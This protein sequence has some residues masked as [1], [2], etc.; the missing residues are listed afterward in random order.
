[1]RSLLLFEPTEELQRRLKAYLMCEDMSGILAKHV[2]E[3]R[4]ELK[5]RENIIVWQKEGF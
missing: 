4:I 1:M 2:Q 5:R 3:I